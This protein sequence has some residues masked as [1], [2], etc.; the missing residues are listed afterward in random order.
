[1]MSRP[2]PLI[3][4]AIAPAVLIVA[5]FAVALFAVAA[6]APAARAADAAP[7]VVY[8]WYA[9]GGPAPSESTC[10]GKT[11]PAYRCTFGASTDDCRRQVQQYLDRW[12]AS[13]NVVFTYTKPARGPYFTEVITSEP[14]SWCNPSYDARVGGVSPIDCGQVLPNGTC[15]AFTCA[16]DPRLCATIVAQ[17]Q[18]HLA[19]LEHT[20]SPADAMY[21]YVSTAS[22]GFEDRDSN[23]VGSVCGAVTQNS[24]QL[25][26]AR[27]G[28]W[29][30]GAKPDP[31]G[32]LPA[33]DGGIGGTIPVPTYAG[34]FQGSACGC[35]AAGAP[36][37][38]TAG[39]AVALG[40]LLV[41][42]RRRISGS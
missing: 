37:A 39:L 4:A 29:P 34:E 12:Y 6:F 36:D 8:L 30:G 38:S 14:G 33:Y 5:A 42:R 11:P 9:D 16:D 31:Y 21:V 25:M 24:Y 23:V 40:A 20:D 1:M 17:E 26:L 15:Y 19:G 10:A 13:L 18:A 35:A 3:P 41:R 2:S 7:A 22:E 27:M 32:P 28:A